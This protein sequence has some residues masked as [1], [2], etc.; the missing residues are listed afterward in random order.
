MSMPALDSKVA[1]QHVMFVTRRIEMSKVSEAIGK[2]ADFIGDRLSDL[3]GGLA[4][5]PDP[6][7]VPV[8]HHPPRR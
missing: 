5:Q 3:A 6:I 7:P 4:P 2:L 8:R 1:P